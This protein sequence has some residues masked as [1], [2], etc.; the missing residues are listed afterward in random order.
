ILGIVGSYRKQGNTE[1][2]IK[3]AL[4]EAENHGIQTEMIRLTDYTLKPCKGCMACIFKGDR[5]R[6]DDDFYTILD[7]IEQ[8]DGVLLGSPTYILGPQG[9]F[10][11]LIDRFL[12][13]PQH[14]DNL[15][16]KPASTVT[17]SGLKN[18]NS[19]HVMLNMVVL[20][21]GMKLIDA[22]HIY[23]PGPGQAILQS[24]QRD[25]AVNI[26]KNLALAVNGKDSEYCV[27]PVQLSLKIIALRDSFWNSIANRLRTTAG[28]K[29][30]W[31]NTWKIG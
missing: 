14:L 31:K 21:F 30:A 10:K 29:K 9:Q 28:R 16:G 5:C 26:G 27:E 7:L 11:L 3:I 24:H 4:R 13:I 2:F 20:G 8:S 18:W 12:I 25:L 22:G 17:A 23:G 1:L 6:I 15:M 19:L